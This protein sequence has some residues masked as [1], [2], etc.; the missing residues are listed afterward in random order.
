MDYKVVWT[1]R[2]L[3]DLRNIAAF[4]GKDNPAAAI[5][6]GVSIPGWI[7]RHGTMQGGIRIIQGP[8]NSITITN[9]VEFASNVRSLEKKLQTVLDFRENAMTKMLDFLA[10]KHARESGFT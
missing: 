3:E 5:K 2:S 4:I 8:N 6:L 10:M 9:A 1:L 7:S